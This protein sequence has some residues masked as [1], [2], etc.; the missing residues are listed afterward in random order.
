M[1]ALPVAAATQRLFDQTGPAGAADATG[2]LLAWLDGP[3]KTLQ[4]LDDLARDTATDP[5][6]SVVLDVNRC[7]TYVLPWLAQF[8]GV[9]FNS[10]TLTDA[11]Q[12]TAIRSEAG[13]ARG[14]LASIRGTAQRYLT[15]SM[16]VTISERTTDPYHLTVTMLSSQL[17]GLRYN[18]LT[19]AY[20]KYSNLTAAFA[21][22]SDYASSQT[23]LVREL[24]AAK[25]AGL[26]LTINFV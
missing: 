14:S 20:P 19:A 3:G 23:E 13:F 5:G 2:T 4:V 7:P 25:P 18:D 24:Q 6:W 15:G 22:Y 12:R 26:I 21:H 11:Q 8:V 9:R 1:T 17:I 10:T 16:Q